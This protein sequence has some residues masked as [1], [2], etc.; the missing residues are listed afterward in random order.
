MA[1]EDAYN[2]RMLPD[3]GKVSTEQKNLAL[4]FREE[5]RG[6]TVIGRV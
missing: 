3:A 4:T 2:K 5:D 1:F 6:K